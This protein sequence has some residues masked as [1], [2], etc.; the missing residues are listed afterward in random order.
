MYIVYLTN[1]D[2]KHFLEAFECLK[3][4]LQEEYSC[5]LNM[6]NDAKLLFHTFDKLL[7]SMA[8]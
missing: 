5:T 1:E 4:E 8:L 2:S 3:K 6:A 7:A